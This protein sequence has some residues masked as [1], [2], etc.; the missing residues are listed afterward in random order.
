[1]RATVNDYDNDSNNVMIQ[2]CNVQ[3][4]NDLIDQIKFNHF[5]IP[6]KQPARFGPLIYILLQK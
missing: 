5:I 1:M 2:K 3:K 6:K 4:S